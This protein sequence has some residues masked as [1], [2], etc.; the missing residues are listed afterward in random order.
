MG[1]NRSK[2]K[3]RSS[4]ISATKSLS[5]DQS[6]KSTSQVVIKSPLGIAARLSL[7]PYRHS[8]FDEFD[9]ED[10][11]ELRLVFRARRYFACCLCQLCSKECSDTEFQCESCKLVYYCTHEHRLQDL[12]NHKELCSVLAEICVKVI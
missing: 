5:S 2:K 7:P 11:D 3:S 9:D 1:R 10:G 4:V 8:E 6:S 12:P